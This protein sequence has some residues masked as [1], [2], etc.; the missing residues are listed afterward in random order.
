[1]GIFWRKSGEKQA[2]EHYAKTL[3]KNP[4]YFNHYW[5]NPKTQVVAFG[6]GWEVAGLSEAEI[7]KQRL[8]WRQKLSSFCWVYPPEENDD[9]DSL[10]ATG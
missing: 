2:L 10:F 1:M 8:T 4:Q 7:W 3:E 6:L 5:Q 9:D